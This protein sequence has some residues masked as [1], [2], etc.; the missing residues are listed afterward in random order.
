MSNYFVKYF[1]AI[2]DRFAR[3]AIE[4]EVKLDKLFGRNKLAGKTT[5]EGIVMSDPAGSS[6]ET[7]NGSTVNRFVAIKVYIKELDDHMFDFDLLSKVSDQEQKINLINNLIGGCYTAYPDSALYSSEPDP[8]FQAGCTVELKFNDQGPQTADHGRMRGLRYTKVTRLSDSRYSE[9]A[10]HFQNSLADD[11]GNGSNSPTLAGDFEDISSKSIEELSPQAQ[12]IIREFMAEYKQNVG[13]N[14]VPTST[15]RTLGAQVRIEHTN[16]QKSGGQEWYRKT[17]GTSAYRTEMLNNYTNYPNDIPGNIEKNV[18]ILQSN[19]TKSA[20]QVG[21][22]IDFSTNKLTF[23][24]G[25]KLEELANKYLGAKK[26]KSFEWEKVSERY[27]SNRAARKNNG[28]TFDGEHFHI[29]IHAEAIGQ[30]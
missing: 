28:T 18:P 4:E 1:D 16:V 10:K 6:A 9:L 7:T 2:Q 29:S 21:L 20:H 17:Y 19:K 14:L 25:V 27:A 30:I 15:L 22:G 13:I 8:K 12:V 23:E 5:F 26:F 3:H 24:Q 11:F